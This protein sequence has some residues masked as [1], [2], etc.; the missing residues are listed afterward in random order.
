VPGTT[1]RSSPLT[2]ALAA[3]TGVLL[4]GAAPA[5][6][7]APDPT[8]GVDADAVPAPARSV[9]RLITELTATHC[10]ELPPVWVVAQV[11]AESGWDAALSSSRAGGPAGLYQFS[12]QN[13]EAAG[14]Q[15][16]ESDPPRGEDVLSAEAHLRVAVPWVCANLRAVTAHLAATGKP[17]APLDAMLVCHIAGC[18]RV[19]GS[20]TGIPEAGEAD[21][22]QRCAQII[23]RYVTAVHANVERFSAPVQAPPS[24]A[25][26]A[27]AAP[28]PWTGG[29]TGCELPDPTGDGCL[30]GA[31]RHGLHAVE[32]VFGSVSGGPVIRSA[33]C[34]DKHAWNPRSDHSRGRACDLFPTDPGT[35]PK[36]AELESGWRVADWLRSNAG[37]LQVKYLIWQGR[38]WDPEVEDSGDGW[39]ERYTGGGIY[40]VRDPTGGHFD[41]VHISFRE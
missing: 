26:R 9:L 14:G 20:T 33:G 12:A 19:T 22:G 23:A 4:I 38:Y 21:C 25:A 15:P 37:P 18:G 11:Q 3:L 34:W 29:A 28:A 7:P 36:G 30:T 31:T 40:D 13:W 41:H 39:G 17:T 24:P 10:P 6:P 35:F 1:R 2:A 5:A 32:A 27:L 16:W 8:S